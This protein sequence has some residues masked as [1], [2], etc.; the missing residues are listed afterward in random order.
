MNCNC[1]VTMV[2][3][4]RV[5]SGKP[6]KRATK[7]LYPADPRYAD[8]DGEICNGK[9]IAT[10]NATM[11]GGCGCCGYADLEVEYKCDKCGGQYYSELPNTEETLSDFLTVMI[12]RLDETDV[13]NIREYKETYEKLHSERI[14]LYTSKADKASNTRIKEINTQISDM[15]GKCGL[16]E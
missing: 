14:A 1:K 5:G 6:Y 10:V 15:Y 13:N 4:R 2:D 9:I 8:S 3:A 11:D 7:V 12:A 16:E